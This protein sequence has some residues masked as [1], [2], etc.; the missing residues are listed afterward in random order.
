VG[1]RALESAGTA[2]PAKLANL[3]RAAR[4]GI[5]VPPTLWLPSEQACGAEVPARF[6]TGPLILRSAAPGEDTSAG[7]AA[8]Q[9]H[10]E[11]VSSP[12]ERRAFA[13]AL[14]RVLASLPTNAD[15]RR[16][17]CVFVQPLLQPEE[18]GVAFF[19]GYYFERTTAQGGN[20]SLT[21]GR[22]RGTVTRAH[23]GRADAWSRW[24][25]DVYAV[26][27]KS[28]G[29]APLDLEYARD[30]ANYTLLQARPAL[31]PVRPNPT[32]SLANHLEILGEVPSPWIVSVLER[33]G[34]EATDFFAEA[35][36]RVRTWREPYAFVRQGRAWMNFGFFFR[37]MDH[38]GLPRTWVTEG[39]GG[40][41]TDD[42]ADAR[43]LWTRALRSLPHL[44][45][46]QLASLRTVLAMGAGLRKA[47]ARVAAAET[48]PDLFDA[49]VAA[50]AFALRS[51]F[52]LGGMLSGAVRLRRLIGV[53]G[54]PKVVTAAMMRD[55]DRLRALPAD[56]RAIALSDWLARYGHRGPLESDPLQPRF[57]ELGEELLADLARPQEAVAPR[58]DGEDSPFF[59]LERRR[60]WFRDELMKIWAELRRGLLAAA[61]E[62][63]RQGWLAEVEDVFF[64][65]PEDFAA[66]GPLQERVAAARAVH[67]AHLAVN[68][69][70]T[71]TLDELEE[72]R[73][74]TFAGD[75]TL[76]G[77]GL[78]G[79]PFT[80]T[81]RRV[82]SVRQ[83]L[84][85]EALDRGTVLV[86]RALEP[87]WGVVF[88]RVGAVVAELGGELSHASILLREAG[89]PAVVNCAGAFERLADGDK[90]VL[91]PASGTVENRGQ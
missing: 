16:E 21:S 14:G 68:L 24:L 12:G 83:A 58:P 57:A 27:A 72:A 2:E 56:R 80:G 89:K 25:T 17:G 35:D 30:G 38:W 54:S 7:S 66:A 3:Q 22:A 79:P 73:A 85:S 19:D 82:A 87:S 43:L 88:G 32:V 77:V 4:Q 6:A 46:L 74:E 9:Y 55:Y 70:F 67:A 15:G 81:V 31:F 60:E 62:L 41:S 44:I 18:G 75:G 84:E 49:N 28:F 76:R 71:T 29:G 40:G 61:G 26:F 91:T 48:I 47:G 1:W 78:G 53:R 20:A 11:A 33:A 42:P 37:L 52:A 59:A 50:L 63:V 65:A 45:R 39:V 13:D 90:V 36:A 64:L 51:N 86:V 5:V 69:P 23:V 8:G 34:A 10:S